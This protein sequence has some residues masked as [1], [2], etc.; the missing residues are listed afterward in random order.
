M[1][2]E[3]VR[4]EFR[5]KKADLEIFEM[6]EGAT[7]EEAARSIG[8]DADSIAKTLSL[9]L[10]DEVIIVVM[11]G[12]VKLDNKKYKEVF[13]TKA[14]MLAPEEVEPLTGHPVG[15]V[16]PFGLRGRPAVYLDESLR[17]HDY[18][19]PAAGDRHHAFKIRTRQLQALTDADWVDV[20]K[21]AE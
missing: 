18:V 13:H 17:R 5:E 7:V 16:S 6:G 11:S 2:L 4:D 1:S 15:G 8:V 21:P 14:K 12:K 10:G 19:Y 3:T 9:H 20:C